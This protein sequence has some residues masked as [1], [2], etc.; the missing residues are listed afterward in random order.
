VLLAED[1]QTKKK[2]LSSTAY[3][4]WKESWE[5]FGAV[6]A[7]LVLKVWEEI[8]FVHTIFL[9]NLKSNETI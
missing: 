9:C 7:L 5:N 3:I 8:L 1:T 6:L 4:A 2:S